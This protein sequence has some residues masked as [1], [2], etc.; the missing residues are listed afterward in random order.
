[1]TA[2]FLFV[3]EH[4]N[5][6]AHNPECHAAAVGQPERHTRIL[7][8]RR[9][10]TSFCLAGFGQHC[11][12]RPLHLQ[13]HA[14]LILLHGF[15]PCAFGLCVEKALPE[16]VD[17]LFDPLLGSWHVKPATFEPGLQ[18]PDASLQP[19][20]SRLNYFL[21]GRAWAPDNLARDAV[22]VAP[23]DTRKQLIQATHKM[24]E[25][26][27]DRLSPLDTHKIAPSEP[28]RLGIHVRDL[29]P[30][31]PPAS[32]QQ[33]G[34]GQALD[35]KPK[36]SGPGGAPRAPK[37]DKFRGAEQHRGEKQARMQLR[38]PAE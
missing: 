5:R 9:Q 12:V 3:E 31:Q 36:H 24:P 10:P 1:M 8:P 29:V 19:G 23:L 6:R 26:H 32:Q 17:L 27:V 22:N 2:G 34:K 35:Q 33:H 18:S 25:T 4:P 21:H 14:H 28:E 15:L 7:M 38:A 20:L 37:A 30:G 11:G 13:A 16:T